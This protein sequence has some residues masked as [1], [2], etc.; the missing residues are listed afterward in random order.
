LKHAQD[1]R[2]RFW[3]C[4]ESAVFIIGI[5]GHKRLSNNTT[6]ERPGDLDRTPQ[7]RFDHRQADD[8]FDKRPV[9]AGRKLGLYP[10]FARRPFSDHDELGRVAQHDLCDRV[11]F[12]ELQAFVATNGG[13][14]V[15]ETA[16]QA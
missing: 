9:A 3:P 1:R 13:A 11:G 8:Q 7:R 2:A 14:F 4:L 16:V 6:D 5:P 12:D 15:V 10:P